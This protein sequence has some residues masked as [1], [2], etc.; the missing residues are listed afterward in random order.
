MT[1]EQLTTLAD[2][3]LNEVES[4]MEH[5]RESYPTFIAA[6]EEEIRLTAELLN[7]HGV[8]PLILDRLV[9]ALAA[10]GASVSIEMYIPGFLDGGHGIHPFQ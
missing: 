1:R 9:S 4:R 2:L 10:Q 8:A 6:R 5:D 3:R 7:N